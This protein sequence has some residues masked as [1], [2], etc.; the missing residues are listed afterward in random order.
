V[1]DVTSIKGWCRDFDWPYLVIER[2]M[3]CPEDYKGGKLRITDDNV[4]CSS[5][6]MVIVYSSDAIFNTTHPEFPLV[7]MKMQEICNGDKHAFLRFSLK[8]YDPEYHSNNKVY[9]SFTS[10]ADI[11]SQ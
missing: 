1:A 7:K 9:G 4:D 3:N 5:F 11:L 6:S 8:K 10:N 2:A